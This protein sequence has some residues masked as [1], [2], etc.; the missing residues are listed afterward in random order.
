MT[1]AKADPPRSAAIEAR[2]IRILLAD[3]HR[4]MREGVRTL[5][6]GHDDI[7]VIGEAADGCRAVELARE[8]SPQVI[9]MDLAMPRKSGIEAT[10][11]IV[12]E[13]PG[14]KVIALS[15]HG[16]S[17]HVAGAVGAGA[18]GY[19]LKDTCCK[20]L[21]VAIRAVL[22]GDTY[23]DPGI[24]NQVRGLIADDQAAFAKLTARERQ[25]LQMIADGKSA[26]EI[27]ATLDVSPK[28]VSA[29]REN[30]KHKL[31]VRGT[32]ELTRIA[33]RQGLIALD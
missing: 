13:L 3:D 32:A 4:L 16:D 21:M 5:L 12:A 31:H 9:V 30:L 6:E 29:H 28:T 1:A 2:P 33:I 19:L 10:R 27:A 22:A 18:S 20:E 7:E 24:G 25:V 26:Q 8:L 15:M 17:D 11:Q 23:V 14:V